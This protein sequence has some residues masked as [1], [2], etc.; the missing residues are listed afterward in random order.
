[1]VGKILK[2]MRVT[3]GL[4]QKDLA[5][6]LNV[7]QTTISGWER[8]HREP[9]FENIEKVANICNYEINFTDKTSGE[10]INIDSLKRKDI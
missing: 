10:K 2:Y 3:K 6:L 7:D 9:T 4:Y 8:G 1:M 5:K